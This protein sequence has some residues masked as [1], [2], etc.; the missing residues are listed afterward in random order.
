MAK[1]FRY[2]EV[3]VVQTRAGKL[4]G[5]EF[6]GVFIFKGIPYATA[7][8][9]QKP[10]KVKPW[11]GV[12]EATSYGFVCP[13][14]SQDT[15]S[16]EL[17]VPHRYWPQDENC[18]NLNIWTNSLEKNAGKPV[19]VWLH[20]GGYTA[21]SSIE[22]AA[23]DGFSMCVHGDVVVVTVNHRL[24]ILGFLDLSPYG[25]KYKNSGNEGLA[26][27]VAALQWIKEN[28]EEFGGDQNNITLFG[29]SGGGMKVTGLMQ[30][31]EA[32]GLFHKA[33]VMSGVS[34][35]KLM[36]TLPGDGKE[37][38]GEVLNELNIPESEVER[39]E[40]IPYYELARAY[41]KVCFT[42]AQK[43]QYIGGTPMVNDY[44]KGEP[45]IT[46]FT[47]F[48]KSIPLMVGSVFGEFSFRPY[49]FDK[50]ELTALQTDDILMKHYGEDWEKVKELFI[51][52]YP[53]K[54][55]IDVIAL[56]RIFRQPSKAL[57]R[58][59][60]E[61]GKSPSYLYHFT[62][63]FPY[64]RG[65]VAWHCSDI[66]FVFHN[67][68][69]VEICNIPGVSDELEDVI[70]KAVM[71]FARFGN[72][73]H[74]GIP[75]WSPVTPGDEATMIFDR[76]CE[77]RYNYDDELMKL[78]EEILPPFNLAALFSQDVQY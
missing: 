23:Y 5:Y 55:P 36:P 57:A 10:E 72:P 65:K 33:I 25:E 76:K 1:V 44:Y 78:L 58:L 24:N 54:N 7:K 51:K 45:L 60:A 74:K 73:N 17:M 40:T 68:N 19:M 18:Q 14:L 15:P 11:E 49:P 59:H 6:D 27:L 62:L 34:D 43:G 31:P 30:I 32:V 75:K 70:F 64:Q 67:T 56:D 21:G 77:I 69:L 50:Q 38:I 39:L 3:P 13:L 37:I 2:D 41:N 53:E 9:F 28:I 26:D 47:E 48:G 71:Q 29:Q 42:V 8:R 4:K 46:G 16:A 20:G 63:E 12:K 61:G 22:Q 66:P 52:A 35:G